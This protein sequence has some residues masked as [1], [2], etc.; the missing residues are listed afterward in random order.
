MLSPSR[1]HHP[2]PPAHSYRTN[3]DHPMGLPAGR[4]ALHT[5]RLGFSGFHEIFT[6]SAPAVLL[7]VLRPLPV[8]RLREGF[9]FLLPEALSWFPPYASVISP[10]RPATQPR[11]SA[12]TVQAEVDVVD[13]AHSVGLVI[14][15][16]EG[17]IIHGNMNGIPGLAEAP[18][19]VRKKPRAVPRGYR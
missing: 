14:S 1:Y 11:P 7:P 13:Y 5:G 3:P 19:P 6:S 4:P 9:R 10:A 17:V 15:Q 18:N 8:R 2:H 16:A 12:S